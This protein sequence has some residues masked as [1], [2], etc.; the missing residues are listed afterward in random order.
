MATW[1][2]FILFFLAIPSLCYHFIFS[3]SMPENQ[4]SVLM[5]F[6]RSFVDT[7][8]NLW[9]WNSSDLAPCSWSG[10]TC[11]DA[12]VTSVNLHGF[13][14][15]G[16]LSPTICNLPHLVALNVSKNMI[17]G[18][19]PRE[20]GYCRNLVVLDLSTNRFHS[21]IPP[22]LCGLSSLTRLF[23]SENFLYGELPAGLGNLTSLEELVIY[24]NNLTGI[25]P[26]SIRMLKRLK[27]IRA[28][29]NSLSG[30]IPVEITECDNLE[31]LG[32]AQNKFQ[33]PLPRELCRLQNLTSL[34]LWQNLLSGEIPAELG[35]CTS[36]EMLALRENA[37]NGSIPKELGK[38]TALKRLYI[39]TNSLEGPIP[40]ELGNCVSAVE[41]DLS[42]NRL[43]GIIPAE[44]GWIQNLQLLHLFENNLEGG[45]PRELGQLHMLKRLDLSLNNLS[46]KIPLE[47]QS[48]PS[49]EY[50]QL[51][52]NN[53]SG[54]LPPLIG[55]NSN[56]SVLD[57]S[58]NNLIGSI[59]THVC[60]YQKLFYLSLG[61]NRLGGNIPYGV[62]TCKSLIQLMLGGNQL[63]GSLPVEL[64]GLV[65]LSGLDLYKNRFSGPISPEIGKMR[66]LERLLL[67][68]NYLMG[69]IPPEIG[70]LSQLVYFNISSN[71][72][73]GSIPHQLAYCSKLQ[74]LDL[75]RNQLIGYAPRE[76]GS[77]VNLEQLKLSDNHLNGTIPASLGNLFHLTELQIGG[78]Q[79][80]GHIPIELGQ[81]SALQIA[82]NIS[83]N[84]VSGEIPVELGHLHML[85]LLYLNNNELNGEIPP[86]FSDLPS[87]LVCNLSNNNLAGS[88]PD[89]PIFRRMD[90]SNFIG[91]PAL[92]VTSAD[93]CPHGGTPSS[94][95]DRH[96][97]KRNIWKE[98]TISIASVVV[99][100]FSLVLTVGICWYI[101]RRVPVY[102]SFEEQKHNLSD[103][104]YFPKDGITYQELL[105]AT[106]NFSEGSVIGRGACG[107]VYKAVMSDGT[108]IA[109]K[110]LKS[111]SEG[112]RVDRSF[113]AEITTLG[114]V[115]HRNIVKLFGFCNYHDSNL[116]L[117]E[118]MA[119]GSLGELLHKSKETCLLDWDARYRIA[120][121][122]AEGLRYLHCDCKP[123]IVHRDIKS[124]NI[125][126]DESLE[127][128][129][130]D[131][132][133]AKLVDSS[134]SK[135]MSAV[136]GSYGYIAP[137]YA[138]TMKVTEKCD[139]YSFGVVLLELITGQSPV[140]PPDR[141]GDLVN[142]VRRSVCDMVPTSV[143]DA[144][145]DLSCRNTVEEMSL[146]LKI[147]LFC[148]NESPLD[149]P[150]MREVI[151]MLID[152][153]K[154]S[155]LSPSF[156]TSETPLI[157]LLVSDAWGISYITQELKWS[158]EQHASNMDDVNSAG[159]NW[160]GEL[161]QPC[162]VGSP[163]ELS[164]I[165]TQRGRVADANTRTVCY[166][167]LSCSS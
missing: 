15:S 150:T 107:T 43:T 20:L 77:L 105:E 3:L 113:Q 36:L 50:L 129:V 158:V 167:I 128:H 92:C 47:I 45:I 48:L 56:L 144:R 79:F 162:A 138:F 106:G 117:Y 159:Q 139:I 86:S 6:R 134:F 57:V 16:T 164:L 148:T 101:K 63:T 13:N 61:S 124:N 119:N 88:V 91:N 137:E 66:N 22:E 121:G 44:F 155:C 83:Y 52:N 140:Q 104:S 67:Y 62:K 94:Y 5:E 153:R 7:H 103:I 126:M 151:A 75:S 53:L 18:P 23:L 58:H 1:Q 81:L 42:E 109:V 31:V 156:P 38:L 68:D 149:R 28:G 11:A 26:S 35:N 141:G 29:L 102:V 93:D 125:L 100:F 142:W 74:R 89:N 14:L 96:Q 30:P 118:Y 4:T 114:N 99:G 87:I 41:I 130:G 27:I 76:L 110:R 135:T 165:C 97:E 152:A 80:S 90:A 136:A 116:I 60:K 154:S 70:N 73:S 78:N 51:F 71:R 65:R 49:L 2:P 95:L 10:V 17:Q 19:I 85:E 8:N 40:K 157:M 108:L 59:P 123:Q 39:Y 46:G 122:S 133:L 147:A 24:S 146:V 143:F 64:F 55:A 84:K 37:F 145:L 25:I 127:A 112:S 82:L 32:L 166:S 132:G 115:R 131:F 98:R 9:S 34:I 21:E 160:S 163:V 111:Q 120:L 12:Q 54:I 72:L 161:H 69:Q 33:G